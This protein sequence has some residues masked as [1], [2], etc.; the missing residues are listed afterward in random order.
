[1][2]TTLEMVGPY[3]LG[4]KLGQGGFATVYEARHQVTNQTV[5]LKIL[6]GT[7]ELEPEVQRRF[8][9]EIALLKKLDH[10]N[11][12]R[13]YEAGLHEGSIYC[14]MELVECGT[15][16]DVLLAR[17]SLP[18]REAAEVTV[19]VCRALAHAHERGCVHRDLKPANLYLSES[20]LVKIGDFGLARDLNDSRLTLAGQTVGT[21]RYMPP[22]QITGKDNID[23]RL[24]LYALGCIVFEMVA[25][26][27]PFDGTSYVQIFDQHLEAAPARLDE[28]GARCP[29]GFAD[30]VGYMLAKEPE[31]RPANGNIIADAFEQL[32]ANADNAATTITVNHDILAPTG[33]GTPQLN[34]TQRLQNAGIAEKS[35]PNWKLL[36]IAAAVLIVVV[37][38]IVALKG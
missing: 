19:Q 12:V 27:V 32:L 11:I 23:G 14:A 30:W 29:S 13:L 36:G 15:L 24:D 5:A 20:G 28:I 31:D 9:R 10:P 1:M 25:G 18:W 38:T 35:A 22:E 34:L 16:K 2:S 21:W 7:K 6:H 33:Q 37:T 4:R 17:Y 3:I 26:H 8:V